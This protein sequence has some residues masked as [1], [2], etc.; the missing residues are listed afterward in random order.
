[1]TTAAWNN[2]KGREVR[3]GSWVRGLPLLPDNGDS[4]NDLDSEEE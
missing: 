2:K 4:D 3:C 1:M